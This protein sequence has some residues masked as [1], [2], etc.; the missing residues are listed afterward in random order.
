MKKGLAMSQK[1]KEDF[2]KIKN[3]LSKKIRVSV[4]WDGFMPDNRNDQYVADIDCD[5]FFTADE[6]LKSAEASVGMFDEDNESFKQLISGCKALHKEI[7]RW[8]KGIHERGF[9]YTDPATLNDKYYENSARRFEKQN[10]DKCVVIGP[11]HWLPC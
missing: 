9:T 3:E 8:A 4:G 2:E 10:I 5:T 7:E 6:L 1:V 11:P